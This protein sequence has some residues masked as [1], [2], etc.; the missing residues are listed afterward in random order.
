MFAP[1]FVERDG[2]GFHISIVS[3]SAPVH[4]D[5]T[6]TPPWTVGFRAEVPIMRSDQLVMFMGVS[7]FPP[8]Q[9]SKLT[10]KDSLA[11]E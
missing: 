2:I 1:D 10:I 3:S 8:P 6:K 9:A 5:R 11:Y 7:L 4:A